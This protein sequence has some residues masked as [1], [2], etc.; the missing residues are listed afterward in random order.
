MQCAASRLATELHLRR[1]ILADGP[2]RF[3]SK[4]ALETECGGLLPDTS[5]NNACGRADL[6]ASA[7]FDDDLEFGV[8]KAFLM[9]GLEADGGG[10]GGTVGGP[11]MV[12]PEGNLCIGMSCLDEAYAG[13]GTAAGLPPIV[14]GG[15]RWEP[16]WPVWHS[17][18]DRITR[19][20]ELILPD[21]SLVIAKNSTTHAETS[22]DN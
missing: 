11:G 13:S 22:V 5:P 17:L 16:A 10:G 21:A 18:R 20:S 3:E 15:P 8:D 19:G 14:Q 12:L 7:G 6:A 9:F 4:Q 1:L 2:F